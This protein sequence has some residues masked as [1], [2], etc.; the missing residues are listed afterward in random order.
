MAETDKIAAPAPPAEGQTWVEQALGGEHPDD[1]IAVRSPSGV[2]GTVKRKDLQQAVGDGFRLEHPEETHER[3]LEKAYGDAPVAAFVGGLASTVTGGLSDT[4]AGERMREQA[5]R[6]TGARALGSVAGAFVPIGGGALASGLGKAAGAGVAARVGTGLGGKLAAAGTRGAVEGAVFGGQVGVSEVGL[7][8]TPVTWEGAAATIGSNALG[9]AVLGGG[10]GIGG[11]LLEEG[12]VA[13]KGYAARKLE[14]LTAPESAAVDRG[15]FPEIAAMDKRVAREAIVAERE[16][17]RAQRATDLVEGKAAR[18]TEVAALEKVKDAAARDLYDEAVAYKDFIRPRFNASADSEIRSVLGKSKGSIMRG[19]DNPK[20][21]IEARGSRAVLDGLQKQEN[22]L[23]KVLANADDVHIG[24]DIERQAMLNRLPEPVPG[25]NHYLNPEQSKLYAD[26]AGVKIPKGQP[27]IAVAGED[28]ANFRGAIERGDVNPPQLQRVLDAEEMLARNRTLQAR[29]AEAR[30]PIASDTLA[31]IDARME[32]ARAGVG[33]SP[34]LDALEAHLADISEA[35]LGKRIAQG[36]GALAGGSAGFS[37]GGPLGAAAGGMIGRELGERVYQRLV[38]KIT[39]GNA[40]RAKSVQGSVAQLFA[41]GAGKA[42]KATARVAPLASKIL[43]SIRYARQEYVDGMLGAANARA[44]K[45][46]LVNAFRE[47][48]RELN[49]LTER[50]G[51]GSYSVRMPAREALNQRLQGLWAVSPMVANGVEKTHNARI[52]FLAGKL[53]R[54]PSPPHLQVGPDTWEPSHA[55]LAKFAR[56]MEAVEQPEKVIQRLSTAT[57][58]PEDA[59]VLKTVYPETYREIQG[60][61]HSHMAQLRTS[62]PYAKR[63]GLSIYLDVPVDLALTAEALSVYQR[64]R[65]PL[66]QQQATAPSRPLPQG[67]V[68][69]T[70]AQR[71]SSK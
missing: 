41:T 44:S 47:R 9:G 36:A 64:P 25:T 66:E 69:S 39:S 46:E 61:L 30:A 5:K 42:A 3:D 63:L 50:G 59:E 4:L 2:G 28:L 62:L 35:T 32:A 8:E 13:A 65:A 24:A 38:R 67:M 53:P 55:E 19:L 31:S 22:A 7:S 21:F 15:A 29:F 71:M 10:I 33:K 58:T 49:A 20:G 6:N 11:R 56:Y 68:Q 1:L 51:D 14:Q 70:T 37:V 34:R 26:F 45:S 52:E 48:A 18:E 27:G 60:Q 54:D 43:P 12:A 57:M 17:V 16:T 23:N 40:A